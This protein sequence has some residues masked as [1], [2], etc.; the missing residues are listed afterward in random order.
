MA[1]VP[2]INENLVIDALDN[3]VNR[4]NPEEGLMAHTD[5]GSQ[6]TSSRFCREL[7]NRGFTQSFSRK[8][9]PYDNAAMES[10][11]KTLKRELPLD[12]KYDTRIEARQEI[13]KFIE[14][15]YYTR[16]RIRPSATY[17]PWNMSG[18][19]LIGSIPNVHKTI[20]VHEGGVKGVNGIGVDSTW[21]ISSRTGA[22]GHRD[23]S[24]EFRLLKVLA[25][26]PIWAWVHFDRSQSRKRASMLALLS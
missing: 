20:P 13:F 22:V 5:R 3:A 19:A 17:R 21:W 11:F 18:G 15:Y 26:I 7:E 10:F 24:S 4:E 6:Y 14:L 25:G 8:G 9:C 12:R 2:R 1:S 23:Q 16:R